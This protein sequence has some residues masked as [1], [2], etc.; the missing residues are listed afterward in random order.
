M[1]F[2]DESRDITNLAAMAYGLCVTAVVPAPERADFTPGIQVEVDQVLAGLFRH[3]RDRYQQGRPRISDSKAHHRLLHAVAFI[4][5]QEFSVDRPSGLR[6][7]FARAQAS[8]GQLFLVKIVYQRV[9]WASKQ[10]RPPFWSG[11]LHHNSFT[12]RR[13]GVE[14]L[15]PPTLRV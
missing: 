1:S 9:G 15:E 2:S 14:G 3:V 4:D 6:R 7:R 10:K 5:F 11:L 8:R 13:L 12:Y